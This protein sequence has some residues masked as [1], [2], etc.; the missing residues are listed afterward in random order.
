[1]PH[2]PPP[3]A[4]QAVFVNLPVADLPASKSFFE[5]LGFAF[6]PSFTDDSAACLVLGP[7]HCAML[8]GHARFADFTPRPRVDARRQT[9]VLIALQLDSRA[10]VEALM[11]KALAA[12]GKDFRPADDHGWMYGHAFQDLDGHIWEPFF[13]D[14]AAMPAAPDGARA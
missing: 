8:L 13:M 2:K 9:E 3:L 6:N 12:G 14:R 11:R 10:A 4:V 1:M 5:A 7:S